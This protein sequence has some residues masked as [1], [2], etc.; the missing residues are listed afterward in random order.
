MT[1]KHKRKRANA[2]TVTVS[3]LEV[4]RGCVLSVYLEWKNN[5]YNQKEGIVLTRTQ[6]QLLVDN[7]NTLL[8]EERGDE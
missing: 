1:D 2:P 4:Y 6:A 5:W 7:L 8:N 3:P